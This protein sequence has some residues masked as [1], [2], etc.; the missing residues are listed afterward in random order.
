[1]HIWFAIFI[2][3]K[4]MKLSLWRKVGYHCYITLV[5]SIEVAVVSVA[6][7]ADFCCGCVMPEACGAPPIMDEILS[8]S[9]TN[10]TTVFN[11]LRRRRF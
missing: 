3:V 4:N 11:E 9:R 8:C 1:M 6:S 2:I 7:A 10:E 5:P